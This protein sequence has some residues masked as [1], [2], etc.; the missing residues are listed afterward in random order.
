[1]AKVSILTFQ[2]SYT[3]GA[4]LQAYGLSKAVEKMGHEVR[5]IDYRPLAARRHYEDYWPRHPKRLPRALY[6]H[7]RSFFFR[8]RFNRFRKRY[9]PLT[10]TYLTVED[11]EQSPPLADYIVC[12][13]DQIWN[14]SSFRGFDAA[15]FLSFLREPI[16]QRVSYAATFGDAED[17]GGNK[18]YICS[19]LK[20]FDHIS[21]RDE[22]SQRM[23][24]DLIGRT[25]MHVL[26][27][28]F[29]IDYSTITPP[30]IL[31]PPYILVYCYSKNDLSTYAVQCIHREL[32]IPVISIHASFEDFD[33]GDI[34][35]S[36]PLEWLSLMQHASFVCTDSFHGTCFAI[37][38]GKQFITVAK[39]TGMSRI[40]DILQTAGLSH[41]I[42]WNDE[43]LGTAIEEPI[44][45]DAVSSRIEGARKRS[46]SFLHSALG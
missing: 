13:S 24:Q 8:R 27:P 26:D 15:F 2:Y 43:Q 25:A 23:I 22:R 7:S 10:K 21:V 12:G 6:S 18:Q 34:L 29:L 16:P 40:E 33:D 32:H 37:K 44:E 28:C 39:E 42:I 20:D 14:V 38:N 46:L 4:V 11:L 30:P 9:L 19:L 36:G 31:K 41:R 5:M 45:Y 35:H 3:Y 17:L 1:M